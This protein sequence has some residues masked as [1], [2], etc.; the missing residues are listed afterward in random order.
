MVLEMYWRTRSSRTVTTRS[1]LAL[2]IV[3]HNVLLLASELLGGGEY[4]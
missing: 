3:A 2:D 1:E 4:V